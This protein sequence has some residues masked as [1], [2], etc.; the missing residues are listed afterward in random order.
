VIAKNLD[1]NLPSQEIFAEA[2]V[3][4]PTHADVG[5]RLHPMG[6]TA[7][8]LDRL[9]SIAVVA[10]M[11]LFSSVQVLAAERSR[12]TPGGAVL[13]A[14]VFQVPERAGSVA[15]SATC[16]EGTGG[17]KW[18][19]FGMPFP[20][21]ALIDAN[22]VLVKSATGEELPADVIELARWRHLTN[23]AID[24]V[25][26]RSVLV[27]FAVECKEAGSQSFVVEWGQPRQRQ[28]NS[29]VTPFNLS[30]RWRAQAPPQTG[31]HPAVDNYSS[32]PVAPPVREP[33]VWVSLP[34]A[35]LMR[36]NFRGPVAPIHD[37]RF[38]E[39][40][41][42]YLSTYV[43]DVDRD[44]TQA[45]ASGEGKGY[46]HWG[47]M[48]EAWLYDRPMTLWSMYVN[49]GDAKWLRRAHRASQYYASWIALDNT[50]VPFLRGAFRKKPPTYDR[51]GGDPKYSYAGGLFVAYLLTGDARLLE[52]VKAVADL[53]E[54]Q[55]QTRLLPF[56]RTHGLWTERNLCVALSGAVVAFEATGLATHKRR[57]ATI[58]EGM[59]RD[60]SRPPSGYP[61]E[62]GMEG[63]LLHRPEVH[64]GD[65]LKDSLI[66][67]PWMASL[68][69]DALWHYYVMS[70]DPVALRF[71]S[72]Y[73]QF[74]ASRAIYSDATDPHLRAYSAVW[75]TVGTVRGYSDDGVWADIEHAPDTLSLLAR[76]K[77]AREQL[78]LPVDLIENQMARM[79][80]TSQFV[81]ERWVRSALGT[82]RYRA[83]PMRKVGWWFANSFDLG[84]FGVY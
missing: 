45:D 40:L 56:D 66:M 50:H 5:E 55:V 38:N 32:D 52:P 63:V 33:I 6:M 72:S 27:T 57:V 26:I 73:A 81:M 74:V 67:S 2:R 83:T 61:D 59:M 75:Y 37:R 13:Q 44:V 58:L 76:G 35:W 29:G 15:V 39:F 11:V 77:W 47:E 12:P 54:K 42:G 28:A 51:D 43:N 49:T 3:P 25:S 84:W 34:S 21:G 82:P 41:G 14:R 17:P 64:E 71:L 46:V 65:S 16:S 62:S 1:Q 19:S 78:G 8:K 22:Q 7:R 69:A 31:E 4:R 68:L 9:T 18:A 36:Q 24:G 60:V 80:D 79:K 30:A 20:R 53:V 23:V 10:A 70:D 48:V